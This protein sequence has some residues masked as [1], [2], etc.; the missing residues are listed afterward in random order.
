MGTI[1]DNPFPEALLDKEQADRFADLFYKKITHIRKNL[2]V[3]D[4]LYKI[5]KS[6]A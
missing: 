3:F 6:W 4:T 5:S 2:D 1:K